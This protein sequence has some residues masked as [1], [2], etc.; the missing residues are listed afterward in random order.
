M[1]KVNHGQL[2][3]IMVMVNH[4]QLW[5]RS[6]KV[7]SEC[8]LFCTVGQKFFCT[9]GQKFFASL[10]AFL[11][12]NIPT[13]FYDD[14]NMLRGPNFT[15]KQLGDRTTIRRFRR[16]ALYLLKMDGPAPPKDGGCQIMWQ[17]NY[18]YM[19]WIQAIEGKIITTI[20]YEQQQQQQ[21]GLFLL[22]FIIIYYYLLLFFII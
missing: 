15:L 5:S 1:V 10:I 14:R 12:K 20:T 18:S 22:L 11:I 7:R 21:Q 13:S 4:G 3:S 17:Y 2:W 8:W 9:V 16:V 6:I 19:T